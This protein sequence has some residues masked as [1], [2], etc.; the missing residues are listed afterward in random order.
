MQPLRL[1]R[2]PLEILISERIGQMLFQEA[3]LAA[4][5]TS[6]CS[7]QDPDRAGPPPWGLTP[8]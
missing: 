3:P 6:P 5:P 2:G 1:R 8:P 4:E 7:Q